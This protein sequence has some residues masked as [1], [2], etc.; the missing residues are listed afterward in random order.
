MYIFKDLPELT[1]PITRILTVRS[2]DWEEFIL[3]QGIL[4]TSQM[5]A[6]GDV[7]QAVSPECPPQLR[8]LMSKGNAIF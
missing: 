3:A 5:K 7:T 8:V 4:Q 1:L 6:S 2:T